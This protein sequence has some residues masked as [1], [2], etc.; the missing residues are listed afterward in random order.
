MPKQRG[1]GNGYSFLRNTQRLKLLGKGKPTQLV[2]FEIRRQLLKRF[3]R[4]VK[5]V[6]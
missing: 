6:V 4:I 5:K 1:F 2:R 3:M